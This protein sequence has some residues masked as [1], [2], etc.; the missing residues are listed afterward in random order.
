MNLHFF[1][2]TIISV[3]SSLN[4]KYNNIMLNSISAVTNKAIYIDKLGI[5]I[6]IDE[7]H[8]Q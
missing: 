6:I 3:D 1:Y 4:Q 8:N 5:N 2:R 7:A